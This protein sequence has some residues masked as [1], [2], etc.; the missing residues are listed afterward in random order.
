MT[1][2]IA[3]PLALGALLFGAVA[4]DGD[5]NTAKGPSSTPAATT[6]APGT[7]GATAPATPPSGAPTPGISTATPQSTPT[8]P[9]ISNSRQIVLID[10]DGKRYTFRTMVQMAAGM[11]ATM[12]EKAPSSFCAQSYEEGLKG[13]GKFPAGRAAFMDACEEGWRLGAHPPR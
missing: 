11:R 3:I 13:G 7:P 8:D 4:C 2:K 9:K 6:P 10:P 1:M 5:K 12:G